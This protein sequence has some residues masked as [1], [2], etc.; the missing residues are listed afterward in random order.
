MR[1]KANVAI[2]SSKVSLES[3]NIENRFVIQKTKLIRCD[4]SRQA[5]LL[6]AVFVEKACAIVR[7][8]KES[9]EISNRTWQD[10]YVVRLTH[11]FN[12]LMAFIVECGIN[13]TV[14]EFSDTHWTSFGEW[15]TNRISEQKIS[16]KTV[17]KHM[18]SSNKLLKKLSYA[19]V[20]PILVELN[21]EGLSY[22][23]INKIRESANEIKDNNIIKRLNSPYSFYI[24]KHKRFYDYSKYQS[25]ARLLLLNAVPILKI[26]YESFEAGTTKRIHNT[27]I[28]LLNFLNSQKLLTVNK[29]FFET[30][31]S[32]NFNQITY[33][34]WEQLLYQWRDSLIDPANR[35]SL[36]T[37]HSMIKNL[38]AMWSRLVGS[39]LVPEIN[40]RGY[41]N[42]KKKANTQTRKSLAQISPSNVASQETE[43]FLWNQLK[44]H[45]DEDGYNEAKEFIDTLV[46]ELT[47]EC[48]RKLSINE[49]IDEIYK[50]N[51]KRLKV[52]R[53]F[54]EKEF[55]YWHKHWQFGQEI[56]YS[57]AHSHEDLIDFIDS[58]LLSFSER[59][60]NSAR[61]LYNAPY[62][63]RL[64]N[65]LKY[66]I[67]TKNGILAGT[68]GRYHHLKR[69]FGG[70][71]LLESYVHPH[72]EAT[73]ALWVLILVDTGAN[74]E[75]VREMPW[76]CLS[77]SSSLGFSVINLGN[78]KR[79]GNKIIQ[80]EFQDDTQMGS[81]LSLPQAIR[82][83]K[84]MASKFNELATKDCNEKL[85]I[86]A[87]QA[88]VKVLGEWTARAWFKAFLER[89]EELKNLKILPSMIRPSFL[90]SIQHNNSDSVAAAQIIADH[91]NSQTT[92]LHYTGRTP[93]KLTFNLK[94]REFQE[95]FQ[96]VI[97]A[98]IDGAAEKLGL[99]EEEFKKILSDAARTG[100]GVACLNPMLGIQPGTSVGKSCTRLDACLNCN[101][102]WVVATVDNIIDLI[103]FN[104]YLNDS[105]EELVRNNPDIWENR[106]LPWFVFSEIALTKLS[107]G[108]TSKVFMDA[109]SQIAKRQSSYVA[110]PLY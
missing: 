49:L 67:A 106:W 41:K 87:P 18:L 94:I 93:A 91:S 63:V 45:F 26:Y 29:E 92:L 79:S 73:L 4:F 99:S 105:M 12:Y 14:E 75:V 104:K 98:S 8:L 109:K 54:A 25:L 95:R 60:S 101:M 16:K 80:D 65:A 61:L 21:K 107:Q 5:E 110:I 51:S 43:E 32:E 44:R 66:I 55:I 84:K 68:T 59:K 9:S 81:T 2:I 30:L 72:P 48:V 22:R 40:L 23:H 82:I 6:G 57:E 47:Q 71:K 85:F 97:I 88:E 28:N 103:L 19:K 37:S 52:I 3:S 62:E 77:K 20:I 24:T 96:A 108:E 89:H 35:R 58:P 50:L 100:L 27:F 90:L 102:H 36:K 86:C 53:D 34:L 56:I 15:L 70:R 39:G 13:K 38:A 10:N 74:C 1:S 31:S 42:A 17:S 11:L 64:S 69:S 83:Y 76:D 33:I 7:N 78:K 46:S